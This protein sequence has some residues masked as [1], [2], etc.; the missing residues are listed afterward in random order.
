[1][2]TTDTIEAVFQGVQRL[3]N[4]RFGN[5]RY[6]IFTQN[7]AYLTETDAQVNHMIPDCIGKP[8]RIKFNDAGHIIGITPME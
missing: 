1:M 6:R 3:Q 5:P 2:A 7:G 4:S 8:V